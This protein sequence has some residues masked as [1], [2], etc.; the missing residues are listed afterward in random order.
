LF[1][2]FSFRCVI[3]S[4]WFKDL[5][6]SLV[7]SNLTMISLDVIFFLCILRVLWILK[8]VHLCFPQRLRISAVMTL[9][10]LT[11]VSTFIT[12]SSFSI[13]LFSNSLFLC[14]PWL[15]DCPIWNL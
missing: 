5:S 10:N 6:L 12:R 4:E 14:S 8:N 13:L 11:P 3:F 15:Q 7:F 1:V 9:N 2:P